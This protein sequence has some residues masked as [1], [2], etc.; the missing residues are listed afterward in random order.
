MIFELIGYLIYNMD[1][2][3]K[4]C[5]LIEDEVVFFMIFYNFCYIVIIS[6]NEYIVS[7]RD[8]VVESG[9]LGWLVF[10]RN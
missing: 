1:E 10:K 2:I 6:R 4:K 5:L 9:Y 8:E 7:Y 3:L